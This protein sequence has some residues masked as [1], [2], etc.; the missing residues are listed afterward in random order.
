M[1]KSVRQ[2]PQA[3]TRSSTCPGAS[4]GRGTSEMAKGRSAI[5]FGDVSTAA[6][7]RIA[8]VEIQQQ[9]EDSS[10]RKRGKGKAGGRRRFRF[11]T[12]KEKGKFNSTVEE[13]ARFTGSAEFPLSP[14]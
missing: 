4:A 12:A 7:T 9:D 10:Y 5:F 11:A 1:C 6:F 2:T 3:R 14:A 8:S 13:C